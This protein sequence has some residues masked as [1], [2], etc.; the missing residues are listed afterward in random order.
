MG[1]SKNPWKRK[2]L[3]SLSNVP[4]VAS[5]APEGRYFRPI[6]QC[7]CMVEI[8]ANDCKLVIIDAW[9]KLAKKCDGSPTFRY[10]DNDVEGFL[11]TIWTVSRGVSG[12]ALDLQV[13]IDSEGGLHIST[14]TPG[15]M[16]I[17]EHQLLAEKTV[18]IDCWIHTMPL[19]KAYFTE[20]TWQTIRTWSSAM[21]SVI[22]LGENEYLAYDINTKIAKKV[23]Y[24]LLT[25]A[26]PEEPEED[27]WEAW[28]YGEAVT[29]MGEEE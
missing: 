11:T 28:D 1:L 19:V 2:F 16:P 8:T 6:K 23:Y 25:E 5:D 26:G 13:A 21:K 3:L 7:I 22:V 20:M 17:L 14:G 12:T 18:T 4:S 15:I 24:G 10:P 29:E 9:N 27:D